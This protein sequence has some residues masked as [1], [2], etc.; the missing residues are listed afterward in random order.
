MKFFIENVTVVHGCD[1]NL[2]QLTRKSVAAM[3]RGTNT[4]SR[5]RPSWRSGTSTCCS[6][7]KQ[8]RRMPVRLMT[9]SKPEPA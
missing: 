7:S 3:E 4:E 2:G 8:K 9:R 5:S 6:S 1:L